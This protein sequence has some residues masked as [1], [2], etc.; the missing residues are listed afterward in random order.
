MFIKEVGILFGLMVWVGLM[1]GASY[2]NVMFLTI[3][4]D[5]LTFDQKELA[6]NICTFCNDSGVLLAALLSLLFD[7][8][9]LKLSFEYTLL[10][11][12]TPR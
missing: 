8:T 7:N 5:I 12:L 11:F 2:V 3:S 6:V 10:Y 9:F 4:I 1:G